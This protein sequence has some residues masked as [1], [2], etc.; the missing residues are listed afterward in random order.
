M[1]ELVLKRKIPRE[2]TTAIYKVMMGGLCLRAVVLIVIFL[3]STGDLEPYFLLDDIKYELT[4]K[5]YLAVADG[6]IDLSVIREIIQG[7]YQP[8]WPIVICVSAGFFRTIYAGR[9]LN[10]LLS[11]LC[12]RVIYE[13]V[14]LLTGREKSALLAGKLFAFLPYPIMTCCFPIKDI[15]LTLS[16]LYTFYIF[17]RLHYRQQ[18]TIWQALLCMVGLALTYLARGAVVELM[19]VFLF[20]YLFDLCRRNKRYISAGVLIL[21]AVA[22]ILLFGDYLIEVFQKKNDDYGG[23]VDKSNGLALLQM[24]SASQFYKLPFAYVFATFQPM[25]LNLFSLGS[26][27]IWLRLIY[28]LNISIYPVAIANAFYIFQKKHN[29]VFW[30]SGVVIYCAVISL[31]LGVFRHY[32]FLLPLEIINCSLYFDRTEGRRKHWLIVGFFAALF[33]VMAYSLILIF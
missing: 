7:Y 30:L 17:L 10:I 26:G 13:I 24:K 2:R 5:Y 15:F 25:A 28:L 19:L 31:S 21:I 22:A 3:F 27:N 14:L 18:V 12:I 11:T 20:V 32:L 29:L 6:P 33:V 4:A 9:I 8:F 16:V 23:Y 1:N